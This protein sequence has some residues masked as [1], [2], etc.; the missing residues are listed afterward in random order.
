VALHSLQPEGRRRLP[1]LRELS[2]RHRI[3]GSEKKNST[4]REI[5]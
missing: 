3:I 2:W 4:G 1:N 5:R